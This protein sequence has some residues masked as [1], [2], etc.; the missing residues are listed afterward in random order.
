LH[1]LNYETV[2]HSVYQMFNNH[3]L[4]LFSEIFIVAV[5]FCSLPK[6][7]VDL[8]RLAVLSES[9]ANLDLNQK[10]KVLTGQWEILQ[11]STEHKNSVKMGK[12][13]A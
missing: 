2:C 7:S 10:T 4:Y 9:I 8:R 3:C 5:Q 13:H 1:D 12:F 6:L 11:N